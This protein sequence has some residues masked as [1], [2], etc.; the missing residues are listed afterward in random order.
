MTDHVL[1][2][3]LGTS[4]P[5]VALFTVDGTFVDGDFEP[6]ELHLL[7]DGGAEQSPDSC[8]ARHCR[9]NA[10]YDDP[11]RGRRGRHHSRR[12]HL[13]MVGHRADRP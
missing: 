1:T 5:K 6:V 7:P 4:G 9:C 3:D 10:T 12:G 13:A 2:I 11:R 8:V